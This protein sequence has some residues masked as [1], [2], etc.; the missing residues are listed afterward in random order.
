MPIYEY[1]C[2]DC[3]RKTSLLVLS[4]SK[5][6][7]PKCSHCGGNKL[8]RLFSRFAAVRAKESR[9]ESLADPSKFGDLD[10]RD[11]KSV[12]R[13]ARRM[14][15]EM[16]EEMGGDFDAALEEEMEEHTR[17]ETSEGVEE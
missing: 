10:E 1:E 17:E 3:G 2:L 15:R 13:W 5:V 16:G 9:L 11:P 7:S 8:E 4:I 12:A 14:S 6:F